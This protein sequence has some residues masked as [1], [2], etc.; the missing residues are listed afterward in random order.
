[1][2]IPR[3]YCPIQLAHRVQATLPDA[4]AH[5][6]V[7]V[8]RLKR[9]HEVRLFNGEGGEFEASIHLVAKDAVIV[10]IGRYH[11]VE[12]ESPLKVCLAQAVT[13]GE[14]MDYTLQKAVELGVARIQPLQT[15]R[16]VVRLDQERADKRRRHWHNVVISA[17]EQCGR[18]T[19]PGVAA[20]ISLEEWVATTV[21]GQMRLMLSPAAEKT[22]REFSAPVAE[23]SLLVGPEGGFSKDE[24]YFAVAK[25]F[26]SAR[27]GPRVL[28]TET[29][30]LAALA[31]MQML[32]GDFV[33]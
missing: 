14:K 4:A 5:H 10:D 23:V 28:R 3:L 13:T 18:N 20:I 24:V 19:V 9:G 25:G 8:L 11:N 6:A 17:C 30:P 12:R 32:W 7:R 22:L 33:A 31:A 26:Q 27:L 29:A 2:A 15:Q 16:S 21:A 1:M